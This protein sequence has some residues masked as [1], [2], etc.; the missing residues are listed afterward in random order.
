MSIEIIK[1]EENL[2]AIYIEA[3]LPIEKNAQNKAVI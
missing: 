2:V 3:S 1:E